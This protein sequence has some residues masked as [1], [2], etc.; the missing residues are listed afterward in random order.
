MWTCISCSES[1]EDSFDACWNCGTSRT[2]E[3]DLEF[4]SIAGAN[5]QLNTPDND[6]LA[7]ITLAR[8]VTGVDSNVVAAFC[9]WLAQVAS[10]MGCI[11]SVSYPL[12]VAYTLLETNMHGSQGVSVWVML[13]MATVLGFCYSY[14][15]A[16]VFSHVRTAR[17]I[18]LKNK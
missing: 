1:I 14:A 13:M 5:T 17:N 12:H 3:V 7:E 2:G 9:L 4:R 11:I 8:S 10:I 16:L 18:S 15:M 6:E